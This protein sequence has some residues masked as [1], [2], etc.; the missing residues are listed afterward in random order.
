M[1]LKMEAIREQG[2]APHFTLCRGPGETATYGTA[3]GDRYID[4]REDVQQRVGAD[5]TIIGTKGY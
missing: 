5:T 1:R 3:I 4:I 2:K